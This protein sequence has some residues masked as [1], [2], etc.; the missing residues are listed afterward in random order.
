MIL[1]VSE[2]DPFKVR[3]FV[4]MTDLRDSEDRRH[5]NGTVKLT[6]KEHT[7]PG[8]LGSFY[9]TKTCFVTGARYLDG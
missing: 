7:I 8:K 5:R 4:Q 1:V 3:W 9:H 6:S 2:H